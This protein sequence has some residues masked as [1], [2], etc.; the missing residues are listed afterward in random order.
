MPLGS[1]SSP[2]LRLN[3]KSLRVKAL[4]RC[5]KHDPYWCAA[6]RDLQEFLRDACLAARVLHK[7]PREPPLQTNHG[8][9]VCAEEPA[10][11]CALQPLITLLVPADEYI[12]L[13]SLR[14]DVCHQLLFPHGLVR[15]LQNPMTTAANPPEIDIQQWSIRYDYEILCDDHHHLPWLRATEAALLHATAAH[16]ARARNAAAAL[17]TSGSAEEAEE[18]AAVP[19]RSVED[20][21]EA[22]CCVI[23]NGLEVWVTMGAVH[24][25]CIYSEHLELCHAQS[26]VLSNDGGLIC[27]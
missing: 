16:I 8:P 6:R 12:S 7:G 27:H 10:C 19:R 2:K 21:E 25:C 4:I 24:G 22:L 11:G 18:A 3:D 9:L 13:S 26:M 5:S 15:F 23:T 17:A 14:R 20:A 1:A